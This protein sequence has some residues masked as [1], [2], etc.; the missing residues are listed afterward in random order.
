MISYRL[1]IARRYLLS[2]KEA[3]FITIVSLVSI[4]GITIGVAAL[5][6]V[7]SVFNGFNGL[8]TSILVGFDPHLRIERSASTTEADVERVRSWLQDKKGI[9]GFGAF[10]SGKSMIV[11]RNQSKVI[12]V[13]GLEP[14]KIDLVTGIGKK[15]VLG[16][17]EFQETTGRD[18]VVGLTL[19]DRLGVVTGDSVLLISPAGSQRAL[20]GFGAPA[21]RSFR[22]SGI[23]ESN[24]KDYDAL[25]AYMPLQAAQRLLQSES[26]ISGFEVR[27]SDIGDADAAKEA[28]QKQFG[29]TFQVS[30]WYDLHK[31][32]YSV[33]RI[34][35]WTAYLILCLIIGV[36]SFNLL[37]S[38]TMSVIAKTRDIGILKTMGATNADIISVFRFEGLIVGVVGTVGGSLLGILVCFLQQRYHLF[39]L[40]PTV[41]IIPAIPVEIHIVDFFS[42]AIAAL[43]L[44]YAATLY[45][46][47]RAA[48]LLPAEAIRWE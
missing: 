9:R 37:G 43:G 33:M 25:Y 45:P 46:S 22:V 5:V 34:E 44:S 20:F 39:A 21:V 31:D 42:V 19:A 38:L 32:L 3:G 1:F 13:R 36:A 17:L 2:K 47:R 11:S 16:K 48:S 4:L 12:F 40:D 7:L 23:Y 27:F 10:A 15:M 35:R 26:G 41:Y 28:L 14:S 8:V 24:N 30:T 6:V 18:L 29:E